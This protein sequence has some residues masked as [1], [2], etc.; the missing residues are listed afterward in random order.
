[1]WFNAYS[2][3]LVD[4]GYKYALYAAKEMQKLRR[5]CGNPEKIGRQ[6]VDLHV[7]GMEKLTRKI[8]SV[9]Q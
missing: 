6:K 4:F 5:K 1:M 2:C 8:A 9:Y 7:N 3:V